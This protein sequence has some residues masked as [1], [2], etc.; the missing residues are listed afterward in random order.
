MEG[1]NTSNDTEASKLL[2]SSTSKGANQDVGALPI[3][4]TEISGFVFLFLSAIFFALN[5]FSIHIAGAVFEVPPAVSMFM[6]SV[7]HVILSGLYLVFLTPFSITVGSLTRRQYLLL[8]LR[9]GFGAIAL[10]ALYTAF[11]LIPVG[12][13]MTLFFLSP[14]VTLVLCNIVMGEPITVVDIIAVTISLIGAALVTRPESTAT[15]VLKQVP[16]TVRI[17]GSLLALFA[18]TLAAVAYTVIR[19]MGMSVHFMATIF[20]LG[21]CGIF[22]TAFMGGAI[23]PTQLFTYE[24]G[25]TACIIGAVISFLAQIFLTYGLQRCPG[26]PGTL[27]SNIEIPL[28][29]ILGLVFL[30]EQLVPLRILGAVFVITAALIIGIRQIRSQ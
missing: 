23:T 12:D 25:A 27:M 8:F 26:G 29:Y 2:P 24:G 1:L 17:I 4:T 16:A 15:E 3:R 6:R 14:I 13:A 10:V 9:G 30:G 5:A 22:I 21:F 20:S 18:A 7:L 19:Y 28:T 11:K